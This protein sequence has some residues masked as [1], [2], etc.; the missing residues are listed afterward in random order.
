MIFIKYF[1]YELSTA[2]P[3][4]GSAGGVSTLGN[5]TAASVRRAEMS[6][7]DFSEVERNAYNAAFYALGLRWYWDIDTYGALQQMPQAER[8]RFYLE[9]QQPQLL[10]AYDVDFLVHAIEERKAHCLETTT[11]TSRSPPFNWAE[12]CAGDLGA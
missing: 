7:S 6:E 4:V 10:T 2:L 3:K 5:P 9:T 12:A 1:D 8:L 11:S